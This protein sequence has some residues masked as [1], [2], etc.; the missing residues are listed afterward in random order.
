VQDS[1]Q[2]SNSESKPLDM[3]GAATKVEHLGVVSPPG[4]SNGSGLSPERT[5]RAPT[6]ADS[7]HRPSL[8]EDLAVHPAEFGTDR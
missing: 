3:P 2:T 5:R 6:Q 1:G 4:G 8:R 7:K